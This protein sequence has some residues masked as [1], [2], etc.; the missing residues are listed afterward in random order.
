MIVVNVV[1]VHHTTC[2]RSQSA[3]RDPPR[4]RLRGS[5][6]PH[7]RFHGLPR[8]GRPSLFHP[9]FQGNG[10]SAPAESSLTGRVLNFPKN[11]RILPGDTAPAFF[12]PKSGI[13]CPAPPCL[14]SRSRRQGDARGLPR[15]P[16]PPVGRPSMRISGGQILSKATPTVRPRASLICSGSGTGLRE[17]HEHRK[18]PAMSTAARRRNRGFGFMGFL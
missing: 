8:P 15:G 13:G 1:A 7:I 2:S 3:R 17:A 6:F 5:L 14:R 12:C 9:A 10:V 16:A 18:A 4:E 11:V